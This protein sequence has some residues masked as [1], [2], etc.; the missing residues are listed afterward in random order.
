MT[1][2]SEAPVPAEPDAGTEGRGKGPSSLVLAAISLVIT[3]VVVGVVLLLGG[4]ISELSEAEEMHAISSDTFHSI[5]LGST[6]AET[7]SQAGEEPAD[8]DELKEKGAFEHDRF[9]DNCIYYNRTDE[10][11]VAAVF[12][13]CFTNG[14]LTSKHAY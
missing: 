5:R 3:V 4:G 12:Q 9:D 2:Q 8:V 10:D 1:S 11:D 13:L 14:K 6:K 7:I